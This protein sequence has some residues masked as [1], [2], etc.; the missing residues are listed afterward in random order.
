MG[1]KEPGEGENRGWI[2][3]N[4]V[5]IECLHLVKSHKITAARAETLLHAVQQPDVGPASRTRLRL[6]GNNPVVTRLC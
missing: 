1:G 6:S 3:E 2:S 5:I 4:G